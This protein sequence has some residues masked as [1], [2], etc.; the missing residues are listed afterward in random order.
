MEYLRNNKKRHYAIAAGV[1]LVLSLAG[2]GVA[3]AASTVP[4]FC[5]THG[6]GISASGE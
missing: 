6:S 1:A 5:V 3:S 4:Q 2:A